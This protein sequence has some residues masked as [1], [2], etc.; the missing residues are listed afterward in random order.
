MLSPSYP[1]SS[2]RQVSRQADDVVYSVGSRERNWAFWAVSALRRYS[3]WTE[4]LKRGLDHCQM[5]V[6]ESVAFLTWVI[7]ALWLG[8]GFKVRISRS[9]PAYAFTAASI[10]RHTY[11]FMQ[12][13]KLQ[14]ARQYSTLDTKSKVQAAGLL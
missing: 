5:R 12:D 3:Y 9:G 10:V 1:L 6:E 2:I 14:S 11:T 8:L 13:G 4:A 7:W